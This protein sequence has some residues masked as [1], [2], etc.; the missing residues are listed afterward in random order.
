MTDTASIFEEHYVCCNSRQL[1]SE[2]FCSTE[3]V[4]VQEE[5]KFLFQKVR[6]GRTVQAHFKLLNNSKVSCTLSL[7]VRNV[8]VKV[9]QFPFCSYVSRYN[10][11]NII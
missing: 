11:D 10:I 5:N 7:A 6:V 1:S 8:G 9:R 4:Y 3:C 2:P